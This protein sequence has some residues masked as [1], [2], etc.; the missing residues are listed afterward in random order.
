[1]FVSSHTGPSLFVLTVISSFPSAVDHLNSTSA[2]VPFANV[3]ES[4]CDAPS[5]KPVESGKVK[6][7][8]GFSD[9]LKV[10]LSSHS[11]LL[12]SMRSYKPST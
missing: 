7:G 6:N 5:H 1:M 4:N 9:K 8:V 3:G 2:G 10:S 11:A 12:V